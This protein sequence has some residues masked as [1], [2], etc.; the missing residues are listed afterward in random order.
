MDEPKTKLICN[1]GKDEIFVIEGSK[2]RNTGKR[3]TVKGI[4]YYICREVND[5]PVLLQRGSQRVE[6]AEKGE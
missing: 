4:K 1:L 6:L 5:G 3:T 2:F